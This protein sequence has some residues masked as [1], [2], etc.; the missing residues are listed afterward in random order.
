MEV[1]ILVALLEKNYPI[2]EKTK[3]KRRKSMR[4]RRWEL[5]A[6]WNIKLKINLLILG[7]LFLIILIKD[8]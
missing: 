3:K 4:K 6:I 2:S 7:K 8:N 1:L 5:F